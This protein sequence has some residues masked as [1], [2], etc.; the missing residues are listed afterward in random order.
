M[1]TRLVRFVECALVVKALLSGG[2]LAA[3]CGRSIGREATWMW[4]SHLQH[5]LVGRR[6]RWGRNE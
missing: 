1:R 4:V 6:R 2:R 5:D 3:T